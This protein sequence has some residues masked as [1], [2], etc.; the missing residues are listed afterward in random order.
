MAFGQQAIGKMENTPNKRKGKKR[1]G[2]EEREEE[3]EGER[4]GG[5]GKKRCGKRRCVCCDPQI[6]RLGFSFSKTL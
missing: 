3:E 2:G 4:R 5:K 1:E 6:R